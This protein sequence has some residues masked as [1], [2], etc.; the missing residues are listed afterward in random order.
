MLV[1]TLKVH[2]NKRW[3]RKVFNKYLDQWG[4]LNWSCEAGHFQ[5]GFFP[6]WM[7]PNVQRCQTVKILSKQMKSGKLI[8]IKESK[9]PWKTERRGKKVAGKSRKSLH[10]EVGMRMED[11]HLQNWKKKLIQDSVPKPWEMLFCHLLSKSWLLF[12]RKSFCDSRFF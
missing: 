3:M 10:F 7:T 9:K 4:N 8:L 1:S 12:I 11:L 2:F 5:C 6:K